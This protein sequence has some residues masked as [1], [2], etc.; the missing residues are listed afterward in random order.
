[1]IIRNQKDSPLAFYDRSTL[2]QVESIPLLPSVKFHYLP[3]SK[4]LRADQFCAANR[5]S[6][7]IVQDRR[8]SI[9]V[10]G[11]GEDTVIRTSNC[12]ALKLGAFQGME[13]RSR[14]QALQHI[15]AQHNALVRQ[16]IP[17]LT[18]GKFSSLV[19]ARN[20]FRNQKQ[21]PKRKA[22]NEA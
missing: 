12:S 4:D 9:N 15:Q 7:E 6:D 8:G 17:A 21:T 3:I 10:L 19:A 5:P 13:P 2:C 22:T 1:M 16:L 14:E 20:R 11:S 18:I